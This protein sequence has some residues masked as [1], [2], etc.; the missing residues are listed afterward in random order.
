MNNQIESQLLELGSGTVSNT[1]TLSYD[2]SLKGFSGMIR[3]NGSKRIFNI[4]LINQNGQLVCMLSGV[5]FKSSHGTEQRTDSK[6]IVMEQ[7]I[8]GGKTGQSGGKRPHF[9]GSHS[10]G[11][12]IA[13]WRN[14]NKPTVYVILTDYDEAAVDGAADLW[15]CVEDEEKLEQAGTFFEQVDDVNGEANRPDTHEDSEREQLAH[16]LK[17]AHG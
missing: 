1:E 2:K 7:N 8:N 10:D 3:G 4:S 16:S 15:E 14:A 11:T 5:G 12:S 9:S 13:I 6:L 17:L